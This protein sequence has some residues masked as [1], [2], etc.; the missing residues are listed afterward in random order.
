M[1]A[2]ELANAGEHVPDDI[3]IHTTA[4]KL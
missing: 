3:D 2:A 4:G 1:S